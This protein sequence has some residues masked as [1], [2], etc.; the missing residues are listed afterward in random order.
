MNADFWR[1]RI[2]NRS[3]LVARITHLTR[4]DTDDEAFDRLWKILLEKKIIGSG[5]EGYIV[6]DKKAV[7]FQEVPLSSIA[8]N[9]I[10]E[11]SLG[12]KNRYSHFGLRFNK[13]RMYRIGARP[14]IYGK[15]EELKRMLPRDEYWRIV[16]MDLDSESV[17]D[18]SHEREWRLVSDYHFKY[19]DT[20]VIVKDDHYY[21]KFINKCIQENRLDIL[22]GING[23]IPLNTVIS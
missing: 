16:N 6:G 20:E 5:T 1:D 12:G 2:S 19:S 11:D 10:F 13:I 3:D 18:W 14:V 4:G 9:L 7:C 17:V 15:T 8:E 23:I 22:K 21:K